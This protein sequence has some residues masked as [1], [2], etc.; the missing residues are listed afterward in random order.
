MNITVVGQGKLGNVFSL[1][2]EKKGINVF[3]VETNK[4]LLEQLFFKT[5]KSEEPYVEEMLRES[6]MIEYSAN[7]HK[8]LDF[9]DSIYC[10]VAT[11]SKE[12]NSYSHDYIETVVKSIYEYYENGNSVEGKTLIINCTTTPLYCQSLHDRL[13]T[14]GMQV[15]YNL[16]FINIGNIR[17]GLENADIVLVGLPKDRIDKV[18]TSSIVELYTTIMNKKPNFKFL[19]LTGAEIAKLGTNFFLSAKIAIANILSDLCKEMNVGNNHVDAVLEA[20]GS[21]SRIG[22]KF[23]KAGYPASGVCL[24]RDVRALQYCL[25]KMDMEYDLPD[26]IKATNTYHLNLMYWELVTG[27]V[28]GEDII[29]FDQLSYKSGVP[30]I[31]ESAPLELCKMVLKGGYNVCVTESESVIEQVKPILQQWESQINYKIAE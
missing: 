15:F 18:D 16:E 19:T 25:D 26:Q 13:S 6:R 3:G 22:N 12:D 23:F 10:F 21:D 5:L 2:C 11:P 8:G 4:T 30:L 29:N 1:L 14:I 9:S 17:D 20:I 28:Q 24:P 7:L 31:T 27:K